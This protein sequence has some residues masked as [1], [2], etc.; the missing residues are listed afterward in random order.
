VDRLLSELPLAGVEQVIIVSAFPELD[1]PHRLTV[2]RGDWRGRVSDYLAGAEAAALRSAAAATEAFRGVYL[3]K[4][5]YNPLGP[6][7][8]G[9]TYD[10]RSD[11]VM[12]VGEL[13]DRGYQDAYRQFIDP[14]L[15][16]SG[17]RLNMAGAKLG[18]GGAALADAVDDNP[19]PDD[20]AAPRER[21]EGT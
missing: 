9:G 13:V 14:V 21:E 19:A 18:R 8:V 5:A 4:P 20:D 1:G 6:L 2:P 3:V 12:T 7:D 17:E 16:A 10:Q 15:G 11:R